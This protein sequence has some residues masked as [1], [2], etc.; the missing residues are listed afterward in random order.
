MVGFI[1][2]KA[3]LII[4]SRNKSYQPYFFSYEG[5]N[6]EIYIFVRYK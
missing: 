4:N 6:N 1:M 3:K 5:I 2:M